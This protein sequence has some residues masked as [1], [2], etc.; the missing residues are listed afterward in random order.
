MALVVIL[1]AVVLL[2]VVTVLRSGSGD[3]SEFPVPSPR[4]LSSL[5]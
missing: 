2:S 3:P 5:G 1:V 4:P